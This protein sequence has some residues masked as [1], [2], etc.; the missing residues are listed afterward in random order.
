MPMSDTVCPSLP[1]GGVV[2]PGGEVRGH[3]QGEDPAQDAPDGRPA[4]H[5]QPHDHPVW[6]IRRVL[7]RCKSQLGG[8]GDGEHNHD[9]TTLC[10]LDTDGLRTEFSCTLLRTDCSE[11]VHMTLNSA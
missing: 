5:L 7:S 4:R 10:T 3:R 2:E 1:A 8:R 9:P 11:L 6:D